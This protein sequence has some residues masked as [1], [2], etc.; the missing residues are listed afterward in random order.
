M[1]LGDLPY[2]FLVTFMCGLVGGFTIAVW[3]VSESSYSLIRT[4]LKYITTTGM[5]LFIPLL[6]II[7]I[8]WLLTK[9]T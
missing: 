2:W 1:T 7:L 4:T 6:I 3:I 8:V 9:N 5:W